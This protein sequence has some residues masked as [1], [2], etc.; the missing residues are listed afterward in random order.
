[1]L[2]LFFCLALETIKN[3]RIVNVSSISGQIEVEFDKLSGCFDRWILICE[4]LSS[5]QR[6][7]FLN[8]TICTDLIPGE[9]YR[10]HI[11]IERTG[12]DTVSS[13]SIEIK[14]HS[15]S[16]PDQEETTSNSDQEETTPNPNQ[17]KTTSNPNEEETTSNPNQE[18][19]TS[20][21]NQEK[22][23]SNPNQEKPT[24]N[25]NQEETTS[26]PD[27]EETTPNPNQ[28]KTTLNPNQEETKSI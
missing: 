1:M 11:E 27:Q 4:S 15:T 21:P 14:L 23:T 16:N 8:S 2:L 3:L 12:W 17:E 7:T 22:T 13:N 24:P 5:Q 26:N 20:N 9:S 19:T 6:N 18:K 28:E 10:I 25:P